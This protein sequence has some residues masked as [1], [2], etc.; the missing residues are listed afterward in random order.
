M[1]NK[2]IMF[3]AIVII[4]II[5]TIVIFLKPT[6]LGLDLVGGSRLVLEAQ[7]T[8]TVAKITPEM[9]DSL[10]Y[11]I[12]NRIN[13]LGVAETVVQQTG[14]KRLLIEIP[15]ISDLTKAKEFLGE[16]AELDFRKPGP[17]VNGEQ[18]WLSTGLSGK[19]LSR[20]ILSTNS[21]NGQWVVDLQFNDKGS[22]KF[23]DLTSKMVGQQMAIFFNGEMQSAPVIRE[24][25]LGGN[26][27]ISGGDTGFQYEEA[28]KMVDLL[29]AGALPVPAK[30]IEENTVGPTLGADS[31]EK[32]KVA[33]M[34]GLGLVMLFMLIFYRLPGLIA[35]TALICYSLILFAL[36]KTIPVTLTLAGIAGFILS[37]GMAVDANILIFE[38]TKEELRAGRTLFTAI[39]AGFDR[40][41]T[42]IFDSNM[43]TIITCLILYMLGTSVVKGFALTLALGVIVSMFSAITITKN[44]MHLIFGTGEL[45]YPQ[46]FGLRKDEIGKAFEV[47]E[48]KREKA[49]FGVLE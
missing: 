25:I 36:F 47:K 23:G 43:S 45:K 24:P 48:T 19:D 1:K 49:K 32:S 17:V 7:T 3:W 37:I 18:T 9:M 42:S 26:A 10:K 15:N 34:V 27:Q 21:T 5:S 35:D 14:E 46:L 40:A 31:I 41:F 13:K 33:G 12:E 39:N 38:R 20:A 2:V 28:K 30:I 4:A 6:K 29:N 16:T 44:F 22:K 11:A 8:D